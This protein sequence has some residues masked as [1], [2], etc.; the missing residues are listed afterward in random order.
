MYP[1]NPYIWMMRASSE[2]L[3]QERQILLE[4]CKTFLD[5]GKLYLPPSSR[6]M[7]CGF[8]SAVKPC[9]KCTETHKWESL[10][11]EQKFFGSIKSISLEKSLRCSGVCACACLCVC[12]CVCAC[13][14]REDVNVV[15][16]QEKKLVIG[17]IDCNHLM[18][19][20]RIIEFIRPNM[21]CSCRSLWGNG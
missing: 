11:V 2:Y 4:K 5:V 9:A 10:I 19:R 3:V 1:V 17:A 6:W 21:L 20:H 14:L 18:I 7:F 13:D 8:L 16:N 15:M 12:V